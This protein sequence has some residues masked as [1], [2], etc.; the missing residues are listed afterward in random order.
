MPIFTAAIVQCSRCEKQLWAPLRRNGDFMECD[1]R[2]LSHRHGWKS[3]ISDPPKGDW[4][5]ECWD[6]VGPD[7]LNARDRGRLMRRMDRL[8]AE[9]RARVERETVER[10]NVEHATMEQPEA[11]PCRS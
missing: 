4:C 10:E 5:P 6:I 7:I 9:E 8:Q 2:E 3:R 11:A 1:A